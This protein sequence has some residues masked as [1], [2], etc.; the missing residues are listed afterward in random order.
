MGN[1]DARAIID[2]V[3]IY[4]GM[5]VANLVSTLNPEMV[6]LGGGLF[7]GGPELFERVRRDFVRWAQPFS[8]Q[9]VRLV[10]SDLGERAGLFGAARIA[11]DN[12]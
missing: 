10:V 4:I 12:I 3:V 5:G 11:L 1:P 6:V 8:A 9:R 7:Q 2:E